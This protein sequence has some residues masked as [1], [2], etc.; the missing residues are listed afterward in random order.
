MDQQ[1]PR[2]SQRELAKR[3]KI[4]Q[5][6]IGYLLN[7]KDEQDRHPT[8]QTIEAV[9]AAFGIPVWQLMIPDIPYDLLVSRRFEKLIENYVEASPDGRASVERVAESEVRYSVAE[10]VLSGTK[11]T[12]TGGN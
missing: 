6:A 2:W 5:R 4:S 3:A 8:T 10:S 7:Y 11:K 12:G 9:A 1:T